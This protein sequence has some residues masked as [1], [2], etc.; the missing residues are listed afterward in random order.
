M[1]FSAAT[2]EDFEMIDH[3]EV[4][5]DPEDLAK[6][7]GWL[8][9]TD[10]TADSSEFRRHLSSQAPGTGLWIC[11]T[12]RYQQWHQSDGH[13]SLWVK[14]VPG[15]GKSVIAA[16]M[17]EHLSST[18]DVPVLYFF[19]R[20]IVAANRKPRN[21][22]QDFLAQLLPRCP[23]LQGTL[24]PLLGSEL[25]HLSDERLW[26][27]LLLGL[28]SIEKTYCV[29]DAMDEM[30]LGSNDTFLQRLNGLA[31]FRPES[32]KLFMTSRPKQYLQSALHDASIVHISLEDDLVG[33]DIAVFVAHRLKDV[34]SGD[35]NA[36]LRA[37]LEST[38]CE[39][40]R[41]LFLYARLLVD[42]IIPKLHA[43]G[44]LDVQKL[45]K[46]LPIG[47]EDMY[48][49]MLYQNTESEKITT[50]IQVFLLEFVTHSSRALRLNELA[51]VLASEFPSERLPGTPKN[52][53]RTACAPLLEILEDETVQ[54]IHHSFTEFLLDTERTKDVS[55]DSTP[56]FPVLDPPKVHKRLAMVSLKY[57][58]SG[59]LRHPDAE[60]FEKASKCD[61]DGDFDCRCRRGQK[62]MEDPY[63]YQEARLRY[64]FL[65]YAIKNWAYHCHRYD[66]DDEDFLQAVSSFMDPKSLD[67]R[68]WLRLEW[69][70]RQ[71]PGAAQTPA[72]LH[73]AAFAGMSKY[74]ARLLRDGQI[75]DPL[76][77]DQL[78][79]L[80]WA[81][82]RGH[83]EIATL[84][85]QG[86]ADANAHSCRGVV[87]L[88]EAAKR[89][90]S[91]I[92]KLL[93]DAGVDPIATKTKEN[94]G[95]RLLGGERS[96]KGET[97]IEYACQQGHL[98]TI[99][100]MLPYLKPASFEEVLGRAC[101]CGEFEIVKAV[102]LN[103][104]V[105]PNTRF[106]G[107]TP[108]YV[109]ATGHNTSIVE[110]LLSK[111][112]DPLE[113]CDYQ[114]NYR[115]N[116]AG[117]RLRAGPMKAPI[118]ALVHQ[119]NESTH[120]ACQQILN[121]LSGAGANIDAKNGEGNTP[122]LS[123]FDVR[124]AAPLIAVKSLLEAGADVSAVDRNGDSVL[125]R[126]LQ[127]CKNVE[128]IKLLLDL[129][130]RPDARGSKGETAL[131]QILSHP[132]G[133]IEDSINEIILLLLEKGV[134]PD[135]KNDF[136]R[137][138][139]ES[140]ILTATCTLKTFKLLLNKCD[141]TAAQGCM[142][143][144]G[145]RKTIEE[146][147]QFIELLLSHGASLEGRSKTGKTPILADL[148]NQKAVKALRQLG[149]DIYA[150]DNHGR[151]ILHCFTSIMGGHTLLDV[152]LKYVGYGLDPLVVDNEGNSILHVAVGNF[153]GTARN[154]EFIKYLL[155]AG[156]SMNARNKEGETPLMVNVELAHVHSSS[157]EKRVSLLDIFR[158]HEQKEKLDLN[159]QDN[160]GLAA[161]HLATLRSEFELFSLLSA[162]AD[163]TLV[164]KE[165]RTILH[166]AC[167]AR[168]TNTIALIID[169][170][171]HP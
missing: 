116:G 120:V 108:L 91:T 63:D 149:A 123:L 39:R 7:Q 136:G 147:K 22:I 158:R 135:L 64:P 141:N 69:T 11:N 50:D 13:S 157:N 99:T 4:N 154:I 165:K 16:S 92:V 159:A 132:H 97:A 124:H 164:T 55:N 67:F 19:F 56:Q 98:D 53:A 75:V 156:I 168:Q 131:H 114:P 31:T 150:V 12:A 77:A 160:D 113:M 84:L 87:P 5:L 86:G 57:L 167:R 153:E 111:E 52:V 94:H 166:L 35:E 40:S 88:H 105:S 83:V 58:Q 121:M 142:W 143:L 18:E 122:L 104:D 110:I 93:L 96:T 25:D 74:A 38:I 103:T 8:Q 14:G 169:K 46:S 126:A 59:V 49:T 100:V 48:N 9:P 107:G 128:I 29:V 119:W 161:I 30:E 54:V 61:C 117:R 47:L 79:P 34:L 43:T 146:T 89:N 23:R 24:Q 33:K 170:Y 20:Y 95:G 148:R 42:Q 45:A 65:E 145:S 109:A 137:T 152:F 101:R 78:T 36:Q 27:F 44:Q 85:L 6:L 127:N 80:H 129:G 144:L 162:G 66:A 32:V 17:V 41:G 82:R 76:D 28:A 26:E 171:R 10:Y 125:F 62:K 72:P 130:A 1:A 81:C 15:A 71:V 51:N 37:S 73:V 163:P 106:E 134:R 118:H 90:H 151:G 133:N 155:E 70:R 21:L 140:A 3:R 138:A 2:S 102:L 60:E 115:I 139:L 112:A 68:Q